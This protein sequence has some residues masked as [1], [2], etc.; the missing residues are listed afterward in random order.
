MALKQ[1]TKAKGSTSES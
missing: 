1:D